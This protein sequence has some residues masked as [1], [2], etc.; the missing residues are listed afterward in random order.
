MNIARKS[1]MQKAARPVIAAMVGAGGAVFGTVEIV[2][3]SGILPVPFSRLLGAAIL[4]GALLG[5]LAA[6]FLPRSWRWP[7]IAVTCVVAFGVACFVFKRVADQG[8]LVAE[9]HAERIASLIEQQSIST[10]KWPA[11]LS[12]V[13]GIESIPPP[14]GPWLSYPKEHPPKI[15]G[16][17]VGFENNPPRVWVARRG[18]GAV[19]DLRTRK[20]VRVIGD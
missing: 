20:W 10:H 9:R 4:A 6:L 7:G 14:A 13:T 17:F 12:E 8:L 2:M 18:Y 16:F 5:L 11:D 15:A 1:L 19:Y 3:A